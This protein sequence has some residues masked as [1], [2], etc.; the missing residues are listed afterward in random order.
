MPL[1]AKQMIKKITAFLL[2]HWFVIHLL[3]FLVYV[4][5]MLYKLLAGRDVNPL[6]GKEE[7]IGVFD[8]ALFVLL[9]VGFGLTFAAVYLKSTSLAIRV[10]LMSTGYVFVSYGYI[11]TLD[12]DLEW[13]NGDVP[14][15]NY[16]AALEVN[17]FGVPYVVSTWN[18][19]TTPT[20]DG[21]FR[22]VNDSVLSIITHYQLDAIS[23]NNWDNDAF[24]EGLE[25]INNRP[26]MHPP[27]TPIALAG[28]IKLFPFGQ[29]S[30]EFFMILTS[31]LAVLIV[32]FYY[33]KQG[34]ME[35]SADKIMLLTLLT[36]PV[37]IIFP[38]PSAEQLSGLLFLISV[39]LI[40]TAGRHKTIAY[41]LAGLVIGLTFF[42]KF[43]IIFYIFVQLLYLV[44]KVHRV[45]WQSIISYGSGVLLVFLLFT[46]S[47]YYFWLTFIT[48]FVYTK[49]YAIDNP[50][51]LVLGL[52]KLIYFGPALL[53]LFV[54]LFSNSKQL[55]KQ[56]NPVL[57][58][59]LV[60]LAVLSLYLWDQGTW[61]RY[62]TFYLPVLLLLSLP[63][64]RKYTFGMRD[65]VI[66]PVVNFIF[67][68]LS[69]YF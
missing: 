34:V 43:N 40:Q 27:F 44:I 39:M 8:P 16:N 59:V 62:L 67:L 18:D 53:I 2:K 42:T 17:E 6:D 28:W 64:L 54:L 20:L 48:G 69:L 37:M 31:L 14:W 29:W 5:F 45:G 41:F 50:V 61:N 65:L 55:L 9:V 35:G 24:P 23:F 10:L 11:K 68:V 32:V 52:S 25:Q 30:A 63:T 56:D 60:S 58:P 57:I 13:K 46:W 4:I 36:T 22:K 33:R 49:I 12:P 38:N 3:F 51:S 15:G 21:P 47:G 19:R 26:Y 66:V 1:I 7:V